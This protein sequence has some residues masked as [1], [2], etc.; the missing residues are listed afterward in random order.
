MRIAVLWW[1]LCVVALVHP[2][3]TQDAAAATA[4]APTGSFDPDDP[5]F[6]VAAALA[7]LKARSVSPR[8]SLV[9]R[10]RLTMICLCIIGAGCWDQP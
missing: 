10:L 3:H 5:N 6:D 8:A 2:S 7:E 1:V 9:Q 4:P